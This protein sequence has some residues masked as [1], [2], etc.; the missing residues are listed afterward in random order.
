MKLSIVI[1]NWNGEQMLRQFLP[2]VT[3]S[4]ANMPEVEVCVADNASTDESVS[5]VRSQFPT[6]R[7]IRLDRNYGFAGGYNRAIKQVDSTYT[8]LL[9]SDVEVPTDWLPPLLDYMDTH[10]GTAACQPKILSYS[11]RG[12]F[13]HAGA[14]GGFIDRYGYPFCRGRVMDRVETD[15][16]QYDE[17][18]GH[19]P[20][21][22]ATGAALLV[23][24]ADYLAVGGLD[25]QFFAHMEEI[26][27]CWRLLSRGRQIVCI[28]DSRVWHVGGATLSSAHPRKTYLNFRN[29]LLMLYKNVP[30]SAELFRVMSVRSILDAVACLRFAVTGQWSHAR[31]VISAVRDFHRL[32]PTYASVREELRRTATCPHPAGRFHWCLI[33]Q[34]YILRRRT[35]S[36]LKR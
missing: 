28:T 15:Y 13:E 8:L 29:S 22:W 32:R 20:V 16:G 31:A 7:I 19:H 1:L 3:A 30:T 6:V 2:S 25:E 35:F 18:S 9:N 36:E 17:P 27:L 21:F 33:W 23:R 34:Y 5:L 10:P 11:Q 12:I 26:D 24:T 4:C 14:A